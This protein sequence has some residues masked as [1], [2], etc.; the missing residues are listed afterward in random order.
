MLQVESR[1]IW[2]SPKWSIPPPFT[3]P[4]SLE[5][6]SSTPQSFFAE[7]AIWNNMRKR[8]VSP[9]GQ[10]TRFQTWRVLTRNSQELGGALCSERYECETIVLITLTNYRDPLKISIYIIVYSWSTGLIHCTCTLSFFFSLF[11]F[12]NEIKKRVYIPFV[13][14]GQSSFVPLHLFTKIIISI[15]YYSRVYQRYDKTL[16]TVNSQ[17]LS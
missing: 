14:R 4:S 13:S 15:F 8:V 11:F 16:C 3:P 6:P 7:G 2:W 12:I 5:P 17:K 9:R 10:W 1:H